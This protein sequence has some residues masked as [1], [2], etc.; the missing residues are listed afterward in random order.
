MMLCH[1]INILVIHLNI[2]EQA[3]E[4][5]LSLEHGHISALRNRKGGEYYQ[6]ILYEIL[7]ESVILFLKKNKEIPLNVVS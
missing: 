6:N 1:F 2:P 7:K 4:I 5:N 3:G